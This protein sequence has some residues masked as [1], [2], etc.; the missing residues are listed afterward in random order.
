MVSDFD[1]EHWLLEVG[2]FLLVDLGE[3]LSYRDH[4]VVIHEFVL[5]WILR[6][7]DV[8]D[9]VRPLV[10]PVAYHTFATELS[11]DQL[12]EVVIALGSVTKLIDLLKARCGAHEL[13]DR[14]DCKCATH[15]GLKS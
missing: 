8:C 14:V 4:L 13:E 6:E 9:N 3:V 15:L 12:L 11:A 2:D 10:S 5:D 1:K 7:V